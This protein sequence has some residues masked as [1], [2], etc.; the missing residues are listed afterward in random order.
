MRNSRQS[1]FHAFMLTIGG[2]KGPRKNPQVMSAPLA[3]TVT[4]YSGSLIITCITRDQGV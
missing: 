2:A 3:P 1:E 4:C